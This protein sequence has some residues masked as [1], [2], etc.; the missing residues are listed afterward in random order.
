MRQVKL[1]PVTAAIV[2]AKTAAAAYE[3]EHG[4]IS[5]ASH[6]SSSIWDYEKRLLKP[7]GTI[8]K[9]VMLTVEN[10]SFH[11]K[12]NA[13]SAAL[14]A[15]Q[16]MYDPNWQPPAS[17]L[18]SATE[19]MPSTIET[20]LKQQ[21]VN[22]P[23]DSNGST[24]LTTMLSPGRFSMNSSSAS[25]RNSSADTSVYNSDVP[26]V[27]Y[28]SQMWAAKKAKDTERERTKRAEEELK[29]CSFKPKIRSSSAPRIGGGVMSQKM[30][31]KNAQAIS[32]KNA[33]WKKKRDDYLEAE[34]RRKV[35]SSLQECTF[36]PFVPTKGR[37]SL[38]S[39]A[40]GGRNQQAEQKEE[41]TK[42]TKASMRP[43]A[44]LLQERQEQHDDAALTDTA[45][46]TA[47]YKASD[48]VKQALDDVFDPA[49]EDYTTSGILTKVADAMISISS[50]KFA[51]PTPTPTPP[52]AA[53]GVV[54]S[55][56]DHPYYSEELFLNSS[57][58][59][60]MDEMELPPPPPPKTPPPA[61][62]QFK[63]SVA[64]VNSPVPA[65]QPLVLKM[66]DYP[67]TGNGEKVTAGRR[68]SANLK[69]IGLDPDE[70]RRSIERK[71]A[72]L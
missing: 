8:K 16:P 19:R 58:I 7:T 30:A 10:H 22:E 31:V 46:M 18:S 59:T 39:S 64:S 4:S 37:T 69:K 55:I 2:R 27:Y 50:T 53:T 43:A 11:P 13:K 17:F 36:R 42:T 51:T 40:V 1:N 72:D 45:N 28:R 38:S 20:T 52:S 61:G 71:V 12:I 44:K 68:P 60:D 47:T 54:S 66:T 41:K 32:E 33:A 15:C 48:E 35:E 62:A 56:D 63:L 49:T 25:L 57:Y 23:T 14:M 5:D 21:L 6:G 9:S 29:E 34:R 65:R 70:R 26:R 67:N 3:N 24:L